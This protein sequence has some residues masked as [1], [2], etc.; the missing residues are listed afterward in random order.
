MKTLS[1]NK[2]GAVETNKT[3]HSIYLHVYVLYRTAKCHI[4]TVHTAL[5]TAIHCAYLSL[6]L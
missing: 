6:C 2:S 4:S 3:N 1:S 5:N